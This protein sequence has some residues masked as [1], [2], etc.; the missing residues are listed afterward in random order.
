MNIFDI[1]IL[2]LIGIF[3]V[4]GFIRGLIMEVFTLVGLLLGYVIAMR[5]MS[6]VAGW[7]EKVI[8]IPSFVS[9]MV[10]FFLIFI[11]VVVFFRWLAGALRMI[12]RRTILA[13]IDRSGGILIGLFKGVLMT[14]LLLLL[15]SI[16]P[17]SESA[18][19]EQKNSFLF[20]PI[21]SVAPAVFNF[22]KH[23]FPKTK[24]FYNEAKEVVSSKSK[25]LAEK[26]SRKWIDREV[27]K[28]LD[29][30]QKEKE[31]SAQGE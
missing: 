7:I 19:T 31:E 14:S 4:K 5:E 11:V 13:W 15:F 18:D 16:V 25:E 1:I 22:L 9:G 3:C 6:T 28:R 12:T 30:I 17:V 24:S 2:V 21:R 20:R 23:T 10:S 26:E 29:A 8:N 27:L